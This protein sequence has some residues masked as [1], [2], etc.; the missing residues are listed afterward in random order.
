MVTIERRFTPAHFRAA[1]PEHNSSSPG[2]L[3]AYSATYRTL[4]SDLGGFRER[5]SL[6]AFDRSLREGHDV[7]CCINHDPNLIV[8]R[9]K[10]GTL[11]LTSDAKGL[12]TACDLPDT[13]YARDLWTS[14]TRGDI[15]ECSFAFTVEDDDWS[16]EDDPENPGSRVMVRSLQD[17]RLLDTS[18][19]TYPA[20][21]NTSVW[22]NTHAGPTV[23]SL[24]RSY[25][26]ERLFPNGVPAEIRSH[27]GDQLQRTQIPQERRRRLLNFILSS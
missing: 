14:V 5:I 1:P 25:S 10:N 18:Y 22:N 7:R 21:P 15:S 17:M 26:F 4:S 9:T 24:A 6:G 2:T 19:V 16:D 11:R 8:G 27:V 3:I 12:R 23:A 13:S 20:Y